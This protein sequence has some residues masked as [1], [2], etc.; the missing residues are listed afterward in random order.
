MRCGCRRETGNGDVRANGIWI[1]GCGRAG[2]RNF[3]RAGKDKTLSS[4]QNGEI[5]YSTHDH[6][7]LCTL[8]VCGG[9]VT[10]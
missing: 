4:D 8:N 9:R 1:N 6:V 3:D 10:L 5:Q 7:L 2:T